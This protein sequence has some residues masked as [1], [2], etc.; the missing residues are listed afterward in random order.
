MRLST[1]ARAY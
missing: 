1:T